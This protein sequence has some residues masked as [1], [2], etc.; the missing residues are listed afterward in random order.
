MKTHTLT[1]TM[2]QTFCNSL[3]PTLISFDFL[4]IIFQVIFFFFPLGFR[5]T[6]K[7][8][9]AVIYNHSFFFFSPLNCLVISPKTHLVINKS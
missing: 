1:H 8:G 3:C 4:S 9:L 6:L 7:H 5:I 2:A